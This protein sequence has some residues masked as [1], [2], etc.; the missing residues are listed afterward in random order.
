MVKLVVILGFA[1]AFAA[2]LAV[3]SRADWSRLTAA[4]TPAVD[5]DASPAPSTNPAGGGGGERPPRP[6]GGGGGGPPRDRG[7]GG[8]LAAELGLTP[9]Q[10][11]RLDDIWTDVAERGRRRDHEG[12]RRAMRAERDEAVAALIAPERWG[13][14]EEII[15]EFA[16][17]TAALDREFRE[18]FEQAVE[19]TKQILTPAQRAKY[20][21]LLE[22]HR[23]GPPGDRRRHADGRAETG[24]TSRP[25]RRN[26]TRPSHGAQ[27]GAQ[28]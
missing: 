9:D 28:E 5:P 24:A 19:R 14:Y 13:Q 6:R 17:R 22:R 21:T 23:W 8:W 12:R 3:G 15:G 1:I 7:P 2:G 27:K 10:H 16:D 25:D 20:D 11:K 26:E 18:D 4:T